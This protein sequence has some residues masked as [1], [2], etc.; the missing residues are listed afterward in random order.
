MLTTPSSVSE[1]TV[2]SS[3][4]QLDRPAP[5]PLEARRVDQTP[6]RATHG[7]FGGLSVA[8]LE[9]QH[10]AGGFPGLLRVAR[11][12]VQIFIWE[13]LFASIVRAS[14]VVQTHKRPVDS[15]FV[16]PIPAGRRYPGLVDAPL[17]FSE[18]TPPSERHNAFENGVIQFT[19]W[20]KEWYAMGNSLTQPYT[21][22]GAPYPDSFAKLQPRPGLPEDFQLVEHGA[23]LAGVARR[24]PFSIQTKRGEQKGEFVIDLRALENL[25]PRAPFI[26]TGG[27][28]RFQ[29]G[30]DDTLKT[31]GVE[32]RGKLTRPGEPGWAL[33]EKRFLAGLNSYTTFVEHLVMVHIATAGVW[34][35]VARMA[36]SARHPL[37]ILL[38][39]FTE[40]T[41][42]V[43]N[44]NIDGL[45]LTENSNVPIY[46][47]YTLEQSD[48]VLRHAA[49]NFDIRTLDP[50]HRATVQGQLDDPTFPTVQS[51]V[52]IFRIFR[53]FTTEWCRTYLREIDLETR[54]FCEELDYRVSNGIRKLINIESWD[55]LTVDH[56][57]YILAVGAFCGSVGHHIVN[58][59]T[60]DY[61][62]SFHVMP[63]ALNAEGFPTLGV[64]MEKQESIFSAG[65]K[66]Y[67]LLSE[68]YMPDDT[69]RRIWDQ[70]Q[71][72]LK[73]Y[74]A[75]VERQSESLRPYL[76]HPSRISSS[77]HA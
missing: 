34:T 17:I 37:R 68:A 35:I 58:D 9:A 70:F 30:H 13:Q 11:D 61:F 31:V 72:E 41:N 33:A 4:Q 19:W 45:I 43:N 59:L 7:P 39:P 6:S 48:V 64:V 65:I 49:A 73:A 66:R 62:M 67:K 1:L 44:Y 23:K 56:V 71:N 3:G 5:T 50:E 42:R 54:I 20:L 69:G 63:P 8:A 46:S 51:A 12:R 53:R 32:F 24:G 76:I 47:G 21:A 25:D 29:R 18:L 36:F 60:R 75:E 22:F 55:E 2:S 26:A 40:E 27:L 28:A 16:K 57:A 14:S 38:Q 77:I 74:E 10:R 15:D 52:A